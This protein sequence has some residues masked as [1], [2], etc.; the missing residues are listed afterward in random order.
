[1]C[2]SWVRAF[3]AIIMTMNSFSIPRRAVKAVITNAQ[4]DI[5]FLQRN[6]KARVDGKCNW[7]LPGGLIESGEDDAIALE[8]EVKEEVGQKARVGR[9]L[10]TWTFFRQFDRKTVTVTNY[11]V[12]LETYNLDD[13]K[14]S[15]EH[16]AAQF[17]RRSALPR[18]DV[19]DPSIFVA[20]G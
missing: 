10:G 18:L 12:T 2:S 8:R 1:M 14:L 6:G 9:A 15:K 7:D 20:L 4:G 5:L 13:L 17:V 3:P 11:A 19:K 16:I